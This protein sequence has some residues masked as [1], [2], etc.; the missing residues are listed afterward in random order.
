MTIVVNSVTV[1]RV[2]TNDGREISEVINN[3][4]SV[5]S[6]TL[7][8]TSVF[9]SQEAGEKKGYDRGTL[10]TIVPEYIVTNDNGERCSLDAF[11]QRYVTP[12]YTFSLNTRSGTFLP[13]DFVVRSSGYFFVGEGSGSTGELPDDPTNFNEFLHITSNGSSDL[14]IVP[15]DPSLGFGHISPY[16][17]KADGH[18]P[19]TLIGYDADTGLGEMYDNH[20]GHHT[21]LNQWGKITIDNLGNADIYSA[22]NTLWQNLTR[23]HVVLRVPE[24]GDRDFIT[25]AI[26]VDWDGVSYKGATSNSILPDFFSAYESGEK[27]WVS[28]NDNWSLQNFLPD[29]VS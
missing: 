22:S 14:Q 1:D 19:G 9:D 20:W 27:V 16:F 10:G 17:V 7:E 26:Q 29:P 4:V 28:T 25:L 15:Y 23:L 21:A 8:I 18:I 24:G 5:F 11:W 12:N 3:G 2:K 13:R 6:R